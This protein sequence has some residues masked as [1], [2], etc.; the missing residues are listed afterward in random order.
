MADGGDLKM[1]AEHGA[2][3][4]KLSVEFFTRTIH[5][6]CSQAAVSMYGCQ[7]GGRT[8]KITGSSGSELLR[9]L[10]PGPCQWKQVSQRK[11]SS[12]RM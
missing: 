10:L 4:L 12:R 5:S 1:A 3:S 2:R 9:L 6:N 11:D 8:R 7:S